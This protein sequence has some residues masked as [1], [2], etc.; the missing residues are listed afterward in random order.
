[1]L[2]LLFLIGSS[3][4]FVPRIVEDARPSEAGG[5]AWVPNHYFPRFATPEKLYVVD[6]PDGRPES[7]AIT[8]VSLQGIVNR[9]KPVVYLVFDRYS[10]FWLKEIQSV[11]NIPVSRM[12]SAEGLDVVVREFRTRIRGLVVYDPSVPDTLNVATTIAGLD[13]RLIV[14]PSQVDEFTSKYALRDVLDLRAYVTA[15]MDSCRAVAG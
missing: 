12:G 8:L 14:D 11:T 7:V 9:E 15:W 3:S 2:I 5:P 13:D 6:I 10:E 1:M 4:L